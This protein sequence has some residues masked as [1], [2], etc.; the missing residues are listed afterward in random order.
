MA[1]DKEMIASILQ[2]YGFN[3]DIIDLTLIID[4][5]GH[6][7]DGQTPRIKT[8][9]R[10]ILENNSVVIIKVVK[11]R[12]H[13]TQVMEQ[14][15]RFSETLRQSKIPV[16]KRHLTAN[17][18]FCLE[19]SI[20]GHT[21]SI[22]VEECLP[23]TDLLVIN[24]EYVQQ[25][26]IIMARMHTVSEENNCHIELQTIWDFFDL[27]TDIMQGYR[28][29]VSLYEQYQACLPGIHWAK[30]KEIERIYLKK[31]DH[32]RTIW[33][34]L[35]KYA[36]QGDFST[37]NVIV[38][39]AGA[40]LGLIDFNIAGDEVLVNDL[41][42]QGIFICYIMDLDKGLKDDDRKLLFDLFVAKYLT[43]RYLSQLELS[44]MNEIYQIV[45]SFLWLRIEYLEDCLKQQNVEKTNQFLEETREHLVRPYF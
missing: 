37:N 39:A 24:E 29:Y 15:S 20:N 32:L 38:D 6:E 27:N 45:F 9:T 23:G 40:I 5:V 33:H 1:L 13:P 30:W 3:H 19:K 10:A 21:C 12:E 17:G 25:L 44:V 14:Q 42:T 41:I 8:I 11:E 28:L 36:V 4:Y 18:H 7:A 22:T 43:K 34:Q 26:A 2:E 35:P 31:K 16:P